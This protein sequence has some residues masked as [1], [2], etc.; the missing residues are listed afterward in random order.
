MAYTTAEG[1]QNLLDELAAATDE[2]AV[3]L[4]LLGDAYEGL[5]EASADRLEDLLFKP[6]QHAYGRARRTHSEFAQ[7]SNLPTKTFAPA[8]GGKVITARN[9]IEDAVQ[10]V[11]EADALIAELQDSMLPVEVGDAEVRAGLSEVRTALGSAPSGARELLR[12]LGR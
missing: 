10:S 12:T 11:E 5:D 7:R 3:A 4:A 2:I 6:V 8:P 1:R 9:A